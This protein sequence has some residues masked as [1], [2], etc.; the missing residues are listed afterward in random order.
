VKKTAQILKSILGLVILCGAVCLTMSLISPPQPLPM[1]A[2]L[3]EFS[4]GRAMQDLA[5]IAREPHPMGEFPAHAVVRDYILHEIEK[6]GLNPQVQDTFGVRLVQPGFLIGGAVENILVRLPGSDPTGA[7]LVIAHYDS[8]PGAPGAGDNG[9]GVA[10]LLELLRNLR[11]SSPLRREVIFLF[12]DG[13]EPGLIG[14]YAF[15]AQHPWFEGIRLAINMDLVGKGFPEIAQT[16]QGN[17]Y[18]VQALARSAQKPTYI[19]LPVRLF[20][21][22]DQDLVPFREAGIPGVFFTTSTIAQETHTMLDRTENVDPGSLQ[23]F[24]NHILALVRDLADQPGVEM[25][26]GSG[27]DLSEQLYFPVLGKLVHYPIGWAW[28]LAAMAGSCFLGTIAYGFHRK[29]LTWKGLGSGLLTLLVSLALSL[30]LTYLLWLG[31]QALHP[32]YQVSPFRPH[33]SDDNLYAIGFFVLVLAVA[34]ISI[35]LVR[36]KVTALDLVAGGL[37]FWLAA[38]VT[39]T[40]LIPEM[41]Y[42]VAWALLFGALALLLALFAQPRKYAWA[43]SGLGFLASAIL[44]TF[45]WIPIVNN[46]YQTVGLPMTWLIIGTA[47][48]WIAAILPAL[49]WITNPSH[50]LLPAAALLVC[51]GLL[52]TGH[53]LVGKHSPPPLVN[54]IGYWLDADKNQAYWIAFIGGY[55]TDART[56]TDIQVAF[57][58]EMDDRQN[59][60]MINPVRRPYTELFPEAPPFSVLTSEAPMLALDGPHM[61]VISDEWATD[62][63]IVKAKITNSMHDRLYVIIPTDSQL[64]AITL[65]K[66]A[67]T[68]LPAAP[69]WGLRFDGMPSEGIE[70]TF[71]FSKPGS[72]R[73]LLVEEKTGLPS[74]PG[75]STQPLPGTMPSPGEFYQGI[76]TDFTAIYRDFVLPAIDLE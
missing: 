46:A 25:G 4:A 34:A 14:S 75:L 68:T 10:A 38:T 62:R 8:T 51:L 65:P 58:P 18:L 50:W 21:A 12:V 40:I 31:L 35:A 28:P 74:F 71:E 66:N 13:E 37:L 32:E 33:L 1:D 60:F 2:P 6:L 36:K 30:G 54:S 72:I 29:E 76:P 15:V 59:G 39:V 7:I 49:D 56:T 53:F 44:A 69:K 26:N 41:S 9:T 57:P 5:I 23:H 42:L 43:V 19:S 20:P 45:L 27:I 47:A 61:Q 17:G 63:R 55:R 73:F 64:L 70:I 48:L 16:S 67:R 11:A 52:I 3:T 22:G 24:G